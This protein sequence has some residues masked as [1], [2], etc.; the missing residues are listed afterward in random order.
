MTEEEKRQLIAFFQ[1][2]VVEKLIAHYKLAGAERDLVRRAAINAKKTRPNALLLKKADAL[3]RR[4]AAEVGPMPLTEKT[5]PKAAIDAFEKSMANVR[6]NANSKSFFKR[7]I[8]KLGWLGM[9]TVGMVISALSYATIW[10]KVIVS[11]PVLKQGMLFDATLRTFEEAKDF[12]SE[13]GK[14]LAHKMP[15]VILGRYGYTVFSK[16][17]WLADGTVFDSTSHTVNPNARD[18]KHA[19]LCVTP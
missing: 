17:V 7:R 19:V 11:D 9:M 13:H 1:S 16:G 4:Y 3:L 15:N 12:C 8:G 10:N 18:R 5:D 2:S 14:T 6:N